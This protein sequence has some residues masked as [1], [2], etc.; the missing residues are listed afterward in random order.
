MTTR[1]SIGRYNRLQVAY[2]RG[3]A[4]QIV[5]G[6]DVCVWEMVGSQNWRAAMVG[7][8]SPRPQN[9]PYWACLGRWDLYPGF[10]P[11]AMLGELVPYPQPLP[12]APLLGAE[13]GGARLD[14]LL[15]VLVADAD[16]IGSAIAV[17]RGQNT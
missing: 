10:I 14:G 13:Y 9:S 16:A 3:A 12:L 5:L 7:Q 1:E 11:G 6:G 15:A 4:W 8:R 17:E 2:I